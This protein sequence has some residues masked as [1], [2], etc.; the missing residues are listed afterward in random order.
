MS[1]FQGELRLFPIV[2]MND[3]I[4]DDL[5]GLVTFAGDDMARLGTRFS[6]PNDPPEET[7]PT[8]Q[9]RPNVLFEAGMA[10]GKYPERTVLVHLGK[11]R[12]FSDVAGRNVLYIANEMKNRQGLADRLRTSGPP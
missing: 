8:P 6:E 11:T 7:D 4:A 10:F 3:L 2:E 1:L 5:I 12:P 9:A